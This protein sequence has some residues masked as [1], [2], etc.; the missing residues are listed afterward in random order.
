M[1]ASLDKDR[2]DI[3]F[4]ILSSS[5]FLNKEGLANEVPYF[6]ET[7]DIRDQAIIYRKLDALTKR[8]QS[9]GIQVLSMGLYDF[10]IEH[11]QA[12]EDLEALLAQESQISKPKLYK[13][14]VRMLSLQN[15]TVPE[16]A[17]RAHEASAQ[18]VIV[19]QVGEVYPYI[20]THELL[21]ALQPV[22]SD[23]PVVVFF[24]GTYRINYEEGATLSLFGKQTA[25]YYRAFKLDDYIARGIL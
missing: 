19:W 4:S 7:Y 14:M 18:I 12:S 10:V 11:L 21:S 3:L 23:R 6:I 8:L 20:R 22:L 5:H 25:R 1:T 15:V 2:F 9:V 17:R 24:P 13:E 16:I